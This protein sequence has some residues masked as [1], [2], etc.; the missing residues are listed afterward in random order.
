MFFLLNT[1]SYAAMALPFMIDEETA[2]RNSKPF[3]DMQKK[4]RR[5]RLMAGIYQTMRSGRILPMFSPD[6]RIQP[7]NLLQVDDA[8]AV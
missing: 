3:L 6:H 2:F 8:A 1:V 4:E 5:N 7:L